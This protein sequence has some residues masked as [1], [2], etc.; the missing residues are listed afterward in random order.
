MAQHRRASTSGQ[1]LAV[2]LHLQEKRH[3][4]QDSDVHLCPS[5]MSFRGGLRKHF[6]ATYN[7]VLGTIPKRIDHHPYLPLMEPKDSHVDSRNNMCTWW[8]VSFLPMVNFCWDNLSL[9]YWC[10]TSALNHTHSP[11]AEIPGS[12]QPLI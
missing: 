6:L 4:F 3:S 11:G 1:T 8:V 7:A 12:L 5:R 10:V 2:H 9:L